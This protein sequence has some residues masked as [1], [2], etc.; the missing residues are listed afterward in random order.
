MKVV[1]GRIGSF[2]FYDA[3]GNG[4]PIAAYQC[5]SLADSTEVSAANTAGI[6]G[7]VGDIVVPTPVSGGLA[8]RRVIGVTVGSSWNGNE[9]S[10]CM[11]GSVHVMAN[12]GVTF[13]PT[14]IVHPAA[15]GT[16]TT[17]QT[18]FTNNFD[19]LLPQDPKFPVTYNLS[20]IDDT[21]LPAAG[22][23]VWPLG[24]ALEAATAQYDIIAVHLATAPFYVSAGA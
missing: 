13:T 4:N 22:Q 14:A 9:V 24:Y 3:T 7:E 5:V 8:T 11:D 10:V 19:M 16:R 23:I 1:N 2:V 15:S 20:M 12:A 17:A 21:A 6:R 18:P